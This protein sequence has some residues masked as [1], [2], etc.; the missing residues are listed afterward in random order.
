M[1]SVRRTPFSA[2]G[3]VL[4]AESRG[5]LVASSCDYPRNHRTTA[6]VG[7]FPFS[8]AHC[9]IFVSRLRVDR[10][11]PHRRFAWLFARSAARSPRYRCGRGDAVGGC[12]AVFASRPAPSRMGSHQYPIRRRFAAIQRLR[13][14]PVYSRG[15]ASV[16]GTSANFSGVSRPQMVRSNRGLLE[17]NACP[18]PS[19]RANL[20]NRGRS[21]QTTWLQNGE[22]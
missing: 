1:G 22:T 4:D 11:T 14:R 21:A 17:P 10:P 15:C 19:P 20:G 18:E 13:S 3:I 12:A 9:W 8:R 5:S 7:R 16:F 2:L 6:G